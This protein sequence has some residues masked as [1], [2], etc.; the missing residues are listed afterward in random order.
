MV[1]YDAVCK[2]GPHKYATIY[3]A[4]GWRATG[5]RFSDGFI[6]RDTGS[7][8]WGGC[9]KCRRISCVWNARWNVL[10]VMWFSGCFA[11]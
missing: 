6:L 9:P 4:S 8:V 10:I 7:V 1:I 2:S 11:L 3:S 5:N